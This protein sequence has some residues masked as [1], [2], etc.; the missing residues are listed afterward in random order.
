MAIYAIGD[1]QGC[2]SSLMRLLEKLQ[3]TPEQ[4]TLWIAGDLV[5]R[6]E[7]SLATLRLLKDLSDST[8][9]V[10]AVLGNHDISLLA[11]RYG[12]LKSNPTID[13]ILQAADGDELLDWLRHRPLLH[14]SKKYKIA[15]AHAGIDPQWTVKEAQHYAL[16]IEQRL[17]KIKHKK[18]KKW[19]AQ[20]Y[21]NKPCK[22]HKAQAN[23]Y[24]R[25]RYII[26][27]F[28]RMR[29]LT[30]QGALNFKQKTTPNKQKDSTLIPWYQY[31]Q[32]NN[33]D[34]SILF[35]H[36]ASLGYYQGNNVIA[37]DTGCVWGGRLT[38][39]PLDVST[40]TTAPI[41]IAC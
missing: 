39:L 18:V 29:Y 10:I 23:K 7:D 17:Q 16:E 26:N 14:V 1:I 27:A 25:H 31:P 11:T 24:D 5:N 28:T 33:K 3:F 40:K 13:P 41:S 22:W 12:L 21:G 2:Y 20:V 34:Y 30:T 15:M 19:L 4:D 37:L 8:D 38:A 36:W 6:G 9:S 35:G 32:R